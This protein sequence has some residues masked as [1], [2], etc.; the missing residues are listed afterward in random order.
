MSQEITQFFFD[1][2]EKSIYKYKQV[3]PQGVPS[4]SVG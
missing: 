4:G 1:I 2:K 3:F